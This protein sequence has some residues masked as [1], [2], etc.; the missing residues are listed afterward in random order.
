MK[1]PLKRSGTLTGGGTIDFFDEFDIEDMAI[2]G[3]IRE[4]TSRGN[5]VKRNSTYDNSEDSEFEEHLNYE[6]EY[7][8]DYYEY[9]DYIEKEK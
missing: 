5:K 2:V 7:Y 1:E 3:R 6:D 9:E 4:G 8:D